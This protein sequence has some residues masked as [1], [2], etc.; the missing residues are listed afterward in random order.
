[1]TPSTA[2]ISAAELRCAQRG[3]KLTERRREVL[4]AL[5]ESGGALSAYD[6]LDRCNKRLKKSMPAMSIYRILDFLE[7]HSLVHKLNSK[8]KYVACAHIGCDHQHFFR[9]QFLICSDC[10]TVQEINID[11]DAYESMRKSAADAGFSLSSTQLEFSG[12]CQQC[13]AD[14]GQHV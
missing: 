7:S 14:R 12:S 11:S 8:N 6:L 10:P 3:V 4:A 13:S 2:L 5:I 9:S 1:M